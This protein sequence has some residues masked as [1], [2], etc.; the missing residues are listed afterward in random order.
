ML[1]LVGDVTPDG[2]PRCGTDRE[3]GIALP[4]AK[5]SLSDFVMHP[6]GRC[7]FQFPQHVGEAAGSIKANQQM[8]M[9][10]RAS[11][12]F[13]KSIQAAD[14][15]AEVFVKARSPFGQDARLAVLGS[16]YEVVM[17]AQV[18]GGYTLGSGLAS[19]WDARRFA[20]FG[21]GGVVAGSSTT[22]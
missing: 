12:A 9:V 22:G 4:P 5:S 7:L 2:I 10:G 14:R 8:D 1:L 17:K 20:G 19:L 11:D 13:G 6:R 15:A 18:S 21:S 16:E 3:G